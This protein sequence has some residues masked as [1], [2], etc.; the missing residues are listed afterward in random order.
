MVFQ[1][2]LSVSFKLRLYNIWIIIA[3]SHASVACMKS[4]YGCVEK[5]LQ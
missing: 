5:K 1:E 2:S 3:V 4:P